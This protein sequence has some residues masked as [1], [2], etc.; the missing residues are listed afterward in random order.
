MSKLTL[1]FATTNIGKIRELKLLLEAKYIDVKSLSD[2]PEWTGME[3]EETGATFA[4]NAFIKARAY[5]RL[6]GLLTLADDSGLS[7]E[8]LGGKPGVYSKRYGHTD[9][10]RIHRLL[11]EMTGI[12]DRQAY[13]TS[14][15]VLYDPANDKAITVEGRAD[16]VITESPQG[17]DGFGYD[18]IFYYPPLRKTFGELTEA[19]KNQVSHRAIAFAKIRKPIVKRAR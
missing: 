14:A 1:L 6:S 17:T 8:A 2:Y 19:E 15:L 5:G 4:E 18:P 13:F 12:T 11:Q 10:D 9:T 3:I 16:G 7:V